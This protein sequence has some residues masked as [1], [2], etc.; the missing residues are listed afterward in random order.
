MENLSERDLRY[1]NRGKRA[2]ELERERLRRDIVSQRDQYAQEQRERQRIRNAAVMS[3]DSHLLTSSFAD[4]HPTRVNTPSENV[5]SIERD[6]VN[7]HESSASHARDAEMKVTDTERSSSQ[8]RGDSI[9]F[10]ISR[11]DK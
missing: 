9:S 1:M 11:R 4:E 6:K 5:T 2:L 7:L 8:M 3:A 10:F